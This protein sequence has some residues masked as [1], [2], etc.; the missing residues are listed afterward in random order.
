MKTNFA[1]K[2]LV[3][4]TLA[5]VLAL[6]ASLIACGT[7]SSSAN[8][9]D[10][11]SG[12]V[13]DSSLNDEQ[14]SS[15]EEC[16]HQ[17]V[18]DQAVAPTCESAGLTEGS[19]CELCGEILTPQE[20]VSALGH[21]EVID[22]AVAPTC[23]STG[24][25]E[26][27]HCDVCG[28]VLVEQAEVSVRH[29]EVIDEA[30]APTCENIGLTEGSH[31]DACGEVLVKQEIV[32]A[33]GHSYVNGKCDV[34]GVTEG[35]VGSIEIVDGYIYFGEYPQTIKADSVII[36]SITNEKGYFLGSDGA[37]YAGVTAILFDSSYKFSNNTSVIGGTTYYF[38]VEPIK[39]QVLSTDGVTAK[40]VCASIIANHRYDDSSNNY[41]QSEIRAWLNNEFYNQAYST[42]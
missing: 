29:T 34:C 22:E 39:W 6:S 31:C 36:T 24:L 35:E 19:H 32:D 30:V 25:T 37:W 41:A 21:T 20:E 40:V 26:G 13:A 1:K 5:I 16:S 8:S 12:S 33:L 15:S 42:I 3:L 17:I 10:V 38:K 4:L 18:I 28:K 23:S 9:V 14:S 7:I 27:S 2:L 11:N